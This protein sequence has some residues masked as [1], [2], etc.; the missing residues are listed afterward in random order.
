MSGR[1]RAG[2]VDIASP[3]GRIKTGKASLVGGIAVGIAAFALWAAITR[4]LGLDTIGWTA[5]G[6]VVAAGVGAWIR[7]ADL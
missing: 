7:I 5:A 2:G 4:E 1:P 3:Q 6:L